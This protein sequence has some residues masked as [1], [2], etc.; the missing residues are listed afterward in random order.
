MALRLLDN[1]F[2]VMID[3]AV[4]LLGQTLHPRKT[5]TEEMQMQALSIWFTTCFLRI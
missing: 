4:V 3:V 2:A 5:F 1:S